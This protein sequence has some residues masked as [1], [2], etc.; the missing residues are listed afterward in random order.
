VEVDMFDSI[1]EGELADR[2]ERDYPRHADRR[3]H[4]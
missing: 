2:F 3:E 4:E 1:D